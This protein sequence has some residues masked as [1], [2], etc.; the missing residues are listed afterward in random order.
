MSRS[1]GASAA[2]AAN[3]AGSWHQVKQRTTF[4]ADF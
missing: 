3:E 1:A 2:A 4:D